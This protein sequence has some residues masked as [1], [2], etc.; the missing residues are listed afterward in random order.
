ATDR[1]VGLR[2]GYAPK[3]P[4]GVATLG[5]NTFTGALTAPSF[6]GGGANLT[7]VAKLGA[8]MFSGMQT[9][10]QF[11]GD[12][13]SLTNLPFPSGAATLGTNTFGGAQTAPNVNV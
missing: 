13:S 6:I 1:I 5:A 8:N 4:S 9:A 2:F 12:G 3:T 7:G 11:V 10:P